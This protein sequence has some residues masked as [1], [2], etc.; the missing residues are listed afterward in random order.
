MSSLLYVQKEDKSNAMTIPYHNTYHSTN[1]IFG[2]P[3]LRVRARIRDY[4]K[5]KES[6][7]S[8]RMD[9]GEIENLFD[10]PTVCTE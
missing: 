7:I 2:A 1:S 3:S 6:T 4:G 9:K 8:N 5:D 10:G